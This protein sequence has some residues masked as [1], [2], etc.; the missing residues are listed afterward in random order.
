MNRFA[1]T[2][3][4]NRNI[5]RNS[6]AHRPARHTAKR[7]DQLS[8]MEYGGPVQR[9]AVLGVFDVQDH[10]AVSDAE[11]FSL[12]VRR[13]CADAFFLAEQQRI[14]VFPCAMDGQVTV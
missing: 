5:R 14:E 13:Y 8:V 2:G 9:I 11:A 4:K 10:Q 3:R 1:G 7:C 12:M 6:V